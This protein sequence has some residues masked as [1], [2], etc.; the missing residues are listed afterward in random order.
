MTKRKRNPATENLAILCCPYWMVRYSAMRKDMMDRELTPEAA[1]T[2]LQHMAVGK[3]PVGIQRK[4]T[5]VPSPAI[6]WPLSATSEAAVSAIPDR[7]QGCK[8]ALRDAL[9]RSRTRL[10]EVL[11]GG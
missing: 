8:R 9:P 7:A 2:Q 10:T 1:F 5:F 4:P 11:P 3:L 6:L